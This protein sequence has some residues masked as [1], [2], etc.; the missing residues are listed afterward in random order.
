MGKMKSSFTRRFLKS[1]TYGDLHWAAQQNRSNKT[2]LEVK[3][4]LGNL[5]RLGLGS[6]AHFGLVNGKLFAPGLTCL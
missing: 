6:Q 5:Q 1:H 4:I 3:M 2:I